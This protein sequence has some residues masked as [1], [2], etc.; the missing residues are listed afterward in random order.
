MPLLPKPYQDEVIGS[1]LERA[2]RQ[3]GMSMK[4]LAKSLF[5]NSRSSFSFL[6]T[7]DLLRLA[8]LLGIDSE[9]LLLQHTMFS[10]AV[11]FKSTSEQCRLKSKFLNRRENECIGSITKSISHGVPFRR[12]CP[13]CIQNDT[14]TF[15]E[16]Y[17]RRC[18][19]LP[20]VLTCHH[21]GIPLLQSTERLRD[22]VQ[23]RSLLT[24]AD[25]AGSVTNINVRPEI[26]QTILRLSMDALHS[27]IQSRDEWASFY[28]Q[29][30]QEKGYLVIEGVIAAKKMSQDLSLFF[31]KSLLD[32]A[33]C[34]YPPRRLN[35]WPS[36]LIRECIPLN[37]ATPKHIF[38][39]T[40]CEISPP[41]DG[42]FGYKKPGRVLYDFNAHDAEVAMKVDNVLKSIEEA[43]TRITIEE[44]L[45]RIGIWQLFRH[46][47][48]RFPITNER[49]KKFR[50]SEQSERQI[51]LRPC[52]R[53]QLRNKYSKKDDV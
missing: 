14:K 40:F 6:M 5:G 42:Q 10:Y 43:G 20:G 29:L 48:D 44:L 7:T 32:E 53:N 24:P 30:I 16:A 35:P 47:R 12:M 45:I 13:A 17:W 50:A 4:G 19:L 21:H 41:S 31:G 33:G 9:E 46:N 1:V 49:L 22:N 2:C 3:S 36:L 52:W 51:G 18:H 15:G 27:K 25:V 34:H 38:F 8:H 26:A 23:I 11:A 28:K 37:F 39:K